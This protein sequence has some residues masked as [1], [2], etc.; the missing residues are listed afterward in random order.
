MNDHCGRQASNEDRNKNYYK[1][2]MAG[3]NFYSR[4][5]PRLPY[6]IYDILGGLYGLVYHLLYWYTISKTLQLEIMAVTNTALIV[7]FLRAHSFR[8]T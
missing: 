1:F 3:G 2:K 6:N 5:I 7:N 8:T 4:S